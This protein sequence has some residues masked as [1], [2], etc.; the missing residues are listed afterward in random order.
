MQPLRILLLEDN[1][2][3]AELVELELR[4]GGL[5]FELV[6]A[7]EQSRYLELLES[8]LDIVIS[9]Y[10]LPGFDGL[11]AFALLREHQ[12][13]TPFILVSGALG[14][15]LAVAAMRQG[16]SD[17]LLKDRLTRLPNAVR[18]ALEQAQLRREKEQLQQRLLRADR[19]ESLGQLAAGVAHDLNNILLPI[20]MAAEV[21]P[22]SVQ[23]EDGHELLATIRLSVERGAKILKQLLAFGRG[24]SGERECLKVEA[25][26]REVSA[27]MR[28]TFPRGISLQVQVTAPDAEVLADPTQIQQVL[29]NLCVNARDAMPGGGT[30]T[31]GLS[32]CDVDR[33]TAR[34][35]PGSQAG[36]HAVLSVKDTGSGIA[37]AELDRIFDPFYTTKPIDQ[38][39]GLGLSSV[40]GIVKGHRGFIQVESTP[41]VGSEFR[42]YL[43]LASGQ[44]PVT[45]RPRRD[46]QSRFHQGLVL[47]VDDEPTV[48]HVLRAGLGR[49]GYRVVEASDGEGGLERFKAEGSRIGALVVDLSMPRLDGVGLIRGIRALGSE[50]PIIAM[51]GVAASEQLREL[52]TLGVRHVLQKPF[53]LEDLLKRLAPIFGDA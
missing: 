24:T 3:D 6:R 8:P 31:L 45:G 1:P 35:H 41:G 12:H 16:V 36:P 17:Y 52:E 42:V 9:D 46:S 13:E 40:L 50:L 22:D 25:A 5:E 37:A 48:R 29:L 33:E 49:V 21:L 27:L 32:R 11:S 26:L 14:E 7:W 47:L 20:M 10:N 53:G 30:L 44:E 19:L 39:T 18:V 4:R 2:N 23:G 34:L 15:E 43:P 28:E 51:M 38:G